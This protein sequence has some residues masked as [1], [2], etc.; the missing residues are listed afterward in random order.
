MNKSKM[1][2]FAVLAAVL[3]VCAIFIIFYGS[4]I[5][6][7]H[8]VPI[9]LPPTPS[10]DVSGEPGEEYPAGATAEPIHILKVSRENVQTVIAALQRP[11]SYSAE[12][13]VRL[14]WS[15]G[16]SS[17]LRSVAVRE[18]RVKTILYDADALPA[19]HFLSV[20]ERT[21]LWMEGEKTFREVPKGSLAQ[22]DLLQIPTYE[23]ILSADPAGIESA[24]Y[25]DLDGEAC[26]WVLMQADPSG[27][28]WRYWISLDSGLLIQAEHWKHSDR[29]YQVR[30][31]S[32]DRAEPDLTLFR[33]P[34]GSVPAP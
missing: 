15:G 8:E 6:V 14:F 7:E 19:E 26:I 29:I 32:F 28:S 18:D 13:D 23:D 4:S 33:L 11:Q 20:N 9:V 25:R 31:V 1:T 17:L 27:Y 2:F 16:E 10:G 3:L 22:D 24:E 34:N 30:R 21:Y 5:V 12:Y